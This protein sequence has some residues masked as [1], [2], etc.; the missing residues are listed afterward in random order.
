MDYG[1]FGDI[2]ACYC[3]LLGFSGSG[4]G[5]WTFPLYDLCSFFGETTREGAMD[6]RHEAPG[7]QP[8]SSCPNGGGLA[9]LTLR[10]TYMEPDKET[11]VDHRPR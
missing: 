10:P 6:D 2:V 3:G 5:V 4:F 9:S 8:L 7:S 1:L 11:L